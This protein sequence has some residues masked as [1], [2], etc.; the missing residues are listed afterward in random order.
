MRQQRKSVAKHMSICITLY[1][2][3][4]ANNTANF[5]AKYMN[6]EDQAQLTSITHSC[7]RASIQ[8]LTAAGTATVEKRQARKRSTSSKCQLKLSIHQ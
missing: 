5:L 8:L 3:C 1:I 6:D 2:T 7:R 4:M